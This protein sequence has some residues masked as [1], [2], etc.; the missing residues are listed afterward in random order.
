MEF[1]NAA[2]WKVVL[3]DAEVSTA[4]TDQRVIEAVSIEGSFGNSK[5]AGIG[6]LLR[7]G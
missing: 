5:V 4:N 1:V 6:D 7:T 2:L 3:S